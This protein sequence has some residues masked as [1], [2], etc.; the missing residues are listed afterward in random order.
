M[1]LVVNEQLQQVPES[2]TIQ[3]LLDT[4]LPEQQKG[5]AVAI[6]QT[7]VARTQWTTHQLIPTDKVLIIKATQ[8]G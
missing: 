7:V 3:G 5:V 6:N 8:G 4:I 2:C 1:E